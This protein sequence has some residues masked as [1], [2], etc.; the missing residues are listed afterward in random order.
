MASESLCSVAW[1]QPPK[2]PAVVTWKTVGMAR[3]TAAS[4]SVVVKCVRR[5]Y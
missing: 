3:A 5:F 1:L 4:V 2:C